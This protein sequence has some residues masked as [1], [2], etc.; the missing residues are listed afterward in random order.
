MKRTVMA[1][2]LAGLAAV[3][4]AGAA[5]LDGSVAEAVYAAVKGH[6]A[7]GW[8]RLEAPGVATESMLRSRGEGTERADPYAALLGRKALAVCVAWEE[9]APGAIMVRAGGLAWRNP[10][11]DAA[12]RSALFGCEK[13]KAE[14]YALDCKCQLLSRDDELVLKVP[15]AYLKRAAGED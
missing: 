14:A 13:K 2:V 10:F 1:A 7:A 5:E 11:T 15:E 3:A 12:A 8:E 4:P 9:S 6:M